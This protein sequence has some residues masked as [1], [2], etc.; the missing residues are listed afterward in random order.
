MLC[1]FE[2]ITRAKTMRMTRRSKRGGA[3]QNHES[4]GKTNKE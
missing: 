4:W 3:G 1:D 2:I